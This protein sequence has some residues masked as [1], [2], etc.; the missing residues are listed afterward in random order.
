MSLVQFYLYNILKDNGII[1][2][3]EENLEFENYPIEYFKVLDLNNKKSDKYIFYQKQ[4]K[5]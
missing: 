4:N 1:I 5:F 3:S 2:A